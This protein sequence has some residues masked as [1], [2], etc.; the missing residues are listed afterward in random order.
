[1]CEKLEQFFADCW[2]G[3]SPRL[4]VFTAPR[5]GKSMIVSQ[6]GPAWGFG[7]YPD[8]EIIAASYGDSLARD[9]SYKVQ[10]RIRSEDY[11]LLFPKTRL[12]PCPSRMQ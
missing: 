8:M 9:F 1:M 2:A 12:Q 10:E 4:M 6:E 11:Q 7:K 3:K 5:H